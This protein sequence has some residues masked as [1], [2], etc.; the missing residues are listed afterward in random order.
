MN[1]WFSQVVLI[2]LFNFNC[3]DTFESVALRAIRQ[4]WNKDDFKLGHGQMKQ[5]GPVIHNIQGYVSV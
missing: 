2:E 3:V 5:A 1:S 4:H